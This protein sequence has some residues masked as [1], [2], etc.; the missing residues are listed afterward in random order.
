MAL[1]NNVDF[2]KKIGLKG[3]RGS[4]TG[5]VVSLHPIDHWKGN[6]AFERNIDLEMIGIK[7]FEIKRFN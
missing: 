5:S 1:L 7:L 6:I 4:T 3:T 2:K